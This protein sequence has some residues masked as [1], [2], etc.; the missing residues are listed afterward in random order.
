MGKKQTVSDYVNNLD[1]NSMTGNWVPVG[2][3]RDVHGDCKSS[4]RGKW[5]MKTMQTSSGEYKVKILERGSEIWG[6]TYAAEPSFSDLVS[7]AQSALG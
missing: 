6:K 4:T 3:W 5:T 2:Q 1:A 7:D